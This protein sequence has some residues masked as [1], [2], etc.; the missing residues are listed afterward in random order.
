MAVRQQTWGPSPSSATDSYSRLRE[1]N[2]SPVSPVGNASHSRSPNARPLL[3]N[4]SSHGSRGMSVSNISSPQSGT[5]II[6]PH[7]YLPYG[8]ERRHSYSSSDLNCIGTDRRASVD[9]TWEASWGERPR[10]S[11]GEGGFFPPTPTTTGPQSAAFSGFSP[12][13]RQSSMPTDA[14]LAMFAAVPLDYPNLLRQWLTP[15]D[16]QLERLQL[17]KA[18]ADRTFEWLVTVDGQ[19]TRWVKSNSPDSAV[20]WL[21]DRPGVGKS[22]ATSLILQAV[23]THCYSERLSFAYIFGKR[24]NKL[25]PAP[26]AVDFIKS[27]AF[28]IFRSHPASGGHSPQGWDVYTKYG[29]EIPTFDQAVEFLGEVLK[30][31]KTYLVVDGI[32]ECFQPSEVLEAILGLPTVADGT[33]RILISSRMR[34]D[35]FDPDGLYPVIRLTPQQGVYSADLR[36]FVEDEVS[37]IEGFHKTSERFT[38]AV[39]KVI[40]ASDGNFLWASALLA[41]LKVA[42][43]QGRFWET[44][45]TIPLEIRILVKQEL[46]K[47]WQKPESKRRLTLETLEWTIFCMEPLSVGSFPFGRLFGSDGSF[48]DYEHRRIDRSRFLLRFGTEFLIFPTLDGRFELFHHRLADY[49][50]LTSMEENPQFQLTD[51]PTRL[52]L[53]CVRYLSSPQF[54]DSLNSETYQYTPIHSS[55]A[56]AAKKYLRS[57]YRCLDYSSAHLVNHL[58][59]VSDV[60]TE[61]GSELVSALITFFL[62]TNATTWVEAGQVFDPSFSRS[63]ISSCPELLDWIRSVV[64]VHPRWR[65][66]LQAVAAR[67]EG[68]KARASSSRNL[69][70]RPQVQNRPRSVTYESPVIQVT[71][72]HGDVPSS[73]TETRRPRSRSPR[74]IGNLLTSLTSSSREETSRSPQ[75]RTREEVEQGVQRRSSARNTFPL[76]NNEARRSSAG[77]TFGAITSAIA[78]ANISATSAI[79]LQYHYPVRDEPCSS[80]GPASQ[81]YAPHEQPQLSH[82]AFGPPNPARQQSAAQQQQY[83]SPP[84][85]QYQHQQQPYPMQAYYG[86][87][88]Y[89]Q[90]EYTP[91]EPPPPYMRYA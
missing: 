65:E 12:I 44:I 82:S 62:S 53:S 73:T 3:S 9:T 39:A 51:G 46:W 7:G 58:L 33:T 37:K 66:S 88:G 52:A 75:R 74:S 13:H 42:Q 45:T 6:L 17:Q 14:N 8:G 55:E 89:P 22:V 23:E 78:I 48:L 41:D 38:E 68:L 91:S 80:W 15:I 67:L 36:H 10:S 76:T 26:Q 83:A 4:H 61:D 43:A 32:D 16:F 72:Y 56:G 69:L 29:S 59:K 2:I 11:G 77:A 25:N 71:S 70:A 21:C 34:P 35:S 47:I 24:A 60:T 63:F 5:P 64:A 27:L 30:N 79:P 1:Y 87:T 84:R 81:P 85:Q 28:Q 20:L 54:Q 31:R 19:F 18:R 49:I 90:D 57:K 50:L 86:P 40:A